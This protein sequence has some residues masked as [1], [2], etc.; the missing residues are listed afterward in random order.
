MLREV[1]TVEDTRP[2]QEH[3]S[4]RPPATEGSWHFPPMQWEQRDARMVMLWPGRVETS[5]AQS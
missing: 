4:S 3:H 2:H 1:S 5:L